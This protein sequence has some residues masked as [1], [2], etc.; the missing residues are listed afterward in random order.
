MRILISWVKII[1]LV[2]FF[3]NASILHARIKDKNKMKR[4]KLLTN[5]RLEK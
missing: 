2:C 3:F 1:V 5:I 4:K